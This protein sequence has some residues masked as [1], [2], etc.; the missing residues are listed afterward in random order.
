MKE[1]CG[2]E[3]IAPCYV[4]AS[5]IDKK[6]EAGTSRKVFMCTYVPRIESG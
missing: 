2:E 5:E 6:Y 1:K 4:K 3:F